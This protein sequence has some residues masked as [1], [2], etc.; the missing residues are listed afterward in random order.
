MREFADLHQKLGTKVVCRNNLYWRKVRPFF[1][2][3]LL[4]T[5]VYRESDV[6]AP[7]SWPGGYQYVVAEPARANS[8]LNFVMLDGLRGYS[9]EGLSHRRR[10]LIKS[11]MRRF[12]VRP[13]TNFDEF[14][15]RGYAVFLSFYE[16]TGY[17]FRADRK[18]RP[19][20]ERWA[21]MLFQHPKAILLGGYGA[22]GLAAISC[23]YVID[24]TLHY[25]TLLTDSESLRG[26]IGEVMFHQLR[27]LASESPLVEEICVRGY[28]G[29]NSLDQYYLLRGCKLVRRPARLEM[30]AFIQ[31]SLRWLPA[32]QRAMLFGEP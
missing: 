30:P 20:F 27:V 21:E 3:P 5:S 31:A 7:C 16:R 12:E 23:S 9:L 26:G 14:R 25:A 32:P 19:A 2:R 29:G 8:T 1:Y 17:T 15:D 10:N 6:T 11:A 13:L 28:Q 4:T 24:S 22:N 18:S